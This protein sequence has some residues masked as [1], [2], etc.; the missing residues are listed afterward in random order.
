[1][2]SQVV[3]VTPE[4]AK[5]W[6]DQNTF[7]RPISHGRVS[8][9]ASDMANGYWKL[10]HQGIGFDNQGVLADGQHRLK[11]VIQCGKSIKMMV[12]WGV[13]R[14]GIDELR[15]RTSHDVIKFGKLS[16]WVTKRHLEI[17]SHMKRFF[18][19]SNSSNAMF[20]TSDQLEF[21]EKHKDAICFSQSLFTT[22]RRGIST[23]LVRAVIAVSYYRHEKRKL[24]DFVDK[25]YS[26]VVNG[27][28][29]SSVVRAREM[30]L[31]GR[32]QTGSVERLKTVKK[33]C[34][35]VD[36]F[37]NNQPLSKL[38]EPSVMPFRLEEK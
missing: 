30:L 32:S 19:S 1:M 7:N 26:G 13:D 25:L 11:A 33:L 38:I 31:D 21:A 37:C 9:Y 8:R 14:Q 24:E 3:I 28:K 10:N 2:H 36:A 15:P 22:N 12:T 20:S 16:D 29:E 17:A 5:Q 4:M 18:D 23:A 35:A 6:L 27:T 34:R